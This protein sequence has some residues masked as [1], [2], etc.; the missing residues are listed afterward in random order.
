[1]LMKIYKK[2]HLSIRSLI[3]KSPFFATCTPTHPAIK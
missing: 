2:L 1:M 3:K